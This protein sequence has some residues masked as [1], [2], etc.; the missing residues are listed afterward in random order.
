MDNSAAD[1]NQDETVDIFDL[2]LLKRFL[3]HPDIPAP[4]IF[5]LEDVPS[6]SGDPWYVIDDNTPDFTDLK[7]ICGDTVF[8]YYSPLDELGRCGVTYASICKELMPTEERGEIG[9][10]RPS[11][12]MY[13]GKSNNNKYDFVNGKYVYNRCHLIGFQLA[14]ENANECNLIT[15]TRYLN[16]D[17][18]LPFENMVAD[19]IH[20]QNNVYMNDVHVWYR[21]TPVY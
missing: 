9:S 1:L 4:Y 20:E 3:L 8:E 6:Y 17:G 21:V 19:Y 5:R 7:E 14:G 13:D 2:A 10:V 15:G 12:W 18:M 16:I 11:G